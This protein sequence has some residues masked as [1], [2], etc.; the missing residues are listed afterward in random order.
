MASVDPP[1]KNRQFALQQ[2]ANFPILSDPETILHQLQLS[3]REPGRRKAELSP[4]LSE[5]FGLRS[6]HLDAH[7]PVP[8]TVLNPFRDAQN[9]ETRSVPV[10]REHRGSAND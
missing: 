1:E 9:G 6:R 3:C 7:A 5:V 8:P 4:I 2:G 10:G